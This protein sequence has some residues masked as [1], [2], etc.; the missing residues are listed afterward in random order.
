MWW[1]E[2]VSLTPAFI[3]DLDGAADPPLPPPPLHIN[4]TGFYLNPASTVYTY[5]YLQKLDNEL[6]PF[7]RTSSLDDNAANLINVIQEAY[8]VSANPACTMYT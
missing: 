7:A 1:V 6:G 4:K 5:V 2:H 8:N 3:R